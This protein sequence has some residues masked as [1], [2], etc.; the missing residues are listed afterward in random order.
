MLTKKILF[1]LSTTLLTATNVMATPAS[2]IVIA[3]QCLLK[4][5]N[6]SYTTITSKQGFSLIEVNDAAITKL[7]ESKH[8][9]K[10]PCGGFSDV[11]R[12]W[13]S[14][15]AFRSTDKTTF[16][17][18]YITD[19]KPALR[20]QSTEYKIQYEKETNALINTIQPQTMWSNLTTL[21]SFQDRYA[22]SKN[23]VKAA[24]WIKDKVETMA[25]ETGHDDVTVYFVETGGYKQPSVVAKFGNSNEPGIVIGGHM[26]TLDSSW[27][28]D[29]P[30][31]DDDGSGS[32][33]V[34]ETARNIL[35]SGM[36]FKKP[37]YFV[38]YSA[39]EMG[40]VGSD[41]VVADFKKKK[42]P[43]DAAIQMDMTGYA[44]KNEPTMWLMTDFVSKDLTAF[45]EKLITTYVKQP[46]KFSKC[47]YA[48]SDHAS[49]TKGGI[50]AAFPFEASMG[51][52]D[53]YIHTSNDKMDVLSLDHMTDF[54]KLATAFASELAIPVSN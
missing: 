16:L 7:A 6:I 3:P 11:T 5:A 27:S 13:N 1:A 4:A 43:V 17:T 14:Q 29:K 8:H 46:Y 35:A 52:D 22:N 32:V 30:G 23:G 42:I 26:D 20:K 24:N 36:Q 31:A 51:N 41:Y 33:T 2:H 28:G 25:K 53:P 39:E 50:P 12:A 49:W 21:T 45:L 44:Y 48:C 37:I 19:S 15:P 54:V 9:S 10:Q 18:S 47:G 34:M 38:W 40:L